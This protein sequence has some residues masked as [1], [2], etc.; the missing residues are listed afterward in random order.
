MEL[1]RDLQRDVQVTSTEYKPVEVTSTQN[2]KT[3]VVEFTEKDMQRLAYL[4]GAID[5]R[6]TDGKCARSIL[7]SLQKLCGIHP[8]TKK[9]VRY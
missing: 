3:Y 6:T 5:G 2:M 7:S 1:I 4:V 9:W 8:H